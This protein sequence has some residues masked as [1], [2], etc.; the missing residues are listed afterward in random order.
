[1]SKEKNTQ[2]QILI[3]EEI[4]IVVTPLKKHTEILSFIQ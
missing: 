2:A 4:V 1:M 3:T